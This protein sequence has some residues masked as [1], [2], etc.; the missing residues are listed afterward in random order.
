MTVRLVL[1]LLVGVAAHAASAQV[2]VEGPGGLAVRLA[3]TVQ[4]RVSFGAE[5][6]TMVSDEAGRRERFG[7]GLRRAR[8]EA[9]VVWRGRVGLEF[10]VD[11]ASGEVRP[12]DMYGVAFLG[13]HVQVRAGRVPGAQPRGSVATSHREIDAV[14][15]AAIIGRWADGTLGGSGRDIGL[16]VQYERGPVFAEL[17][18]HDGSGV[19]SRDRANFREGIESPSV[20]GGADRVGLALSG[21]ARFAPPAWGGAEAGAY[22]SVNPRGNARTARDGVWRGYTSAGAHV[23]WGAEPGSRPVRLKLDVVATAYEATPAGGRRQSAGVSGLA[24]VRVLGHGE[25]FGRAER[26]W[27]DAGPAEGYLTGGLS[28]SPSAAAGERYRT[29]RLTLAYA[30]RDVAGAEA[31]LAVLQGQFAF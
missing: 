19:F 3:G 15:R 21:A 6:T 25:A 9:R 28:Y 20:T 18:V 11:G 16:D 26:Y 29:V 1:A 10:D 14:E 7:F 24:A 12:V 13:A 5:D 22:A 17:F 4:P 2:E 8:F 27:P 23:Y 31:H 30:R